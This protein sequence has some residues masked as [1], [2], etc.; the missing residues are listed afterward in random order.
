MVSQAHAKEVLLVVL[1]GYATLV[2]RTVVE[3]VAQPTLLGFAVIVTTVVV[4]RW[5]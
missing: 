1:F 3:P 5:V 4:E 2:I